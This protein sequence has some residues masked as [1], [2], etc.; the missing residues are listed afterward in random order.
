MENFRTYISYESADH[1]TCCDEWKLRSTNYRSDNRSCDS[2]PLATAL[3]QRQFVSGQFAYRFV[4]SSKI[5]SKA[6]F[7]DSLQG[8]VPATVTRAQFAQGIGLLSKIPS[9]DWPPLT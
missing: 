2:G 6:P 4:V 5:H 3:N 9:V 7:L 1:D 8:R